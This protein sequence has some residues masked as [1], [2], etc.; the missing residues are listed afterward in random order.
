MFWCHESLES[1][2]ARRLYRGSLYRCEADEGVGNSGCCITSIPD[3]SAA[4]SLDLVNRMFTA[5]RPNQLWVADNTYVATW[6][7]PLPLN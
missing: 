7:S 3:V 6:S 2:K 5:Q 1:I 4:E